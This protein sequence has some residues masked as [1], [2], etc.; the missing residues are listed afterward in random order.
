MPGGGCGQQEATAMNQ[1]PNL[2]IVLDRSCSMTDVIGGKT[3]WQIAVAELTQLMTTYAGKIRFG[4]TL[5]PDRVMPNCTQSTIP[6]DPAPGNETPIG[7][8]LNKSLATTDMYYPNGPC[9][10]NIDSAIAQASMEPA[11]SDTT[12]KSFAL[13][14]TDG[15]QSGCNAAGGT[16]FANAGGVPNSGPAYY[17]ATDQASLDAALLKI[18]NETLS[19]DFKLNSAP[20][21]AEKIYVFFNKMVEAGDPTNGWTYDATTNTITFHGMS[22]DQLK[23]GS[24]TDLQVIFGCSQPTPQ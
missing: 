10:T 4:I 17:D 14:L 9:V 19:C 18:A 5:F 22:C 23:S 6:F 21:N 20:P 8:L 3:K 1:P 2:L 16:Q 7:M 15:E 24:V 12:R 13:L 11:F